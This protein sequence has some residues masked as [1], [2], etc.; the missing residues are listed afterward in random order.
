M[1]K[2]LFSE[3]KRYHPGYESDPLVKFGMSGPTFLRAMIMF[4]RIALR[5]PVVLVGDTGCGKTSFIE[6]I[7]RFLSLAKGPPIRTLNV[8]GDITRAEVDKFVEEPGILLFDEFNTSGICP[9]I[10][11]KILNS[12]MMMIGAMN[13][14]QKTE[15]ISALFSKIGMPQALR[16]DV[17]PVSLVARHAVESTDMSSMKYFVH[18]VSG[19]IHALEINC[20]PMMMKAKENRW[21]PREEADNIRSLLRA[22]LS[23]S[24]L[25]TH[26]NSAVQFDQARV[27]E[28][29]EFLVDC[30][31]RS[32]VWLRTFMNERAV[33]SFRDVETAWDFAEHFFKE[34]YGTDIAA[35][36]S[37]LFSMIVNFA[38][39]LP[40]TMLV[41]HVSDQVRGHIRALAKNHQIRSGRGVIE[42]RS[43]YLDCLPGQLE[44]PIELPAVL[45][46]A[47]KLMAAFDRYAYST[48]WNDIVRQPEVWK[49]KSFVYHVFLIRKCIDL[50]RNCFIIGLPGTSKSYA[51]QHLKDTVFMTTYMCSRTSSSESLMSRYY[52]AAYV[53]VTARKAKVLCVLEEMGI[54][55]A[56]PKRPLKV[57]HFVLDQG[58]MATDE[59]GYVKCPTVGVSNYAMDFANMSRG[60][61]LYTELPS[62][63]D[64]EFAFA[65]QVFQRKNPNWGR[66]WSRRFDFAAFEELWRGFEEFRDTTVAH[67]ILSALWPGDEQPTTLALRSIYGV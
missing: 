24:V 35:K 64:L 57:L 30:L 7:D 66:E 56:N 47:A 44:L 55:N 20:N 23:A 49:F 3:I 22:R 37:V 41:S 17:V 16:T 61:L 52:D 28:F 26:E 1:K 34:F 53:S 25:R 4:Q 29:F 65:F 5:Q 8:H 48:C 2:P 59:K 38:L 18:E 63:A 40:A 11:W 10:E 60:I 62:R 42:V 58:I 46:P 9:Y 6:L 51:V 31:L 13:P 32:F 12:K 15:E 50:R 27:D 45:S 33:V 39:R 54:A 43:S 19:S 36:C 67:G 21:L 14:Y